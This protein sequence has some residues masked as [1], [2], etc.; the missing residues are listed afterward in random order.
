MRTPARRIRRN[1]PERQFEETFAAKGWTVTKRGWPDF[2]CSRDGQF[3]V[4]E[5]KRSASQGV[6]RQRKVI[7]ILKAHGVPCYRYDPAQGLLAL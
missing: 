1:K 4:V 5:V 7:D 2:I 6:F 3:M